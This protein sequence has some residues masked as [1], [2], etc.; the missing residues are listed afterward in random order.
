MPR[1][2][3]YHGTVCTCH[4]LVALGTWLQRRRFDLMIVLVTYPVHAHPSIISKEREGV[5]YV[6]FQATNTMKKTLPS[7]YLP[8]G[9]TSH[10][11][12]KDSGKK[13]FSNKRFRRSQGRS[14]IMG[15]SGTNAHVPVRVRVHGTRCTDGQWVPHTRL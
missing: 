13:D 5:S 12:C 1:H 8:V 11:G 3:H 7:T 10:Y 2:W 9:T 4:L 15:G 14:E 6:R